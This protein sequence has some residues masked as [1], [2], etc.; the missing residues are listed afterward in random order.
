MNKI[1]IFISIVLITVLFVEAQIE[2]VESP[3]EGKNQYENDI[4]ELNDTVQKYLTMII[5][6]F[7]KLTYYVTYGSVTVA[8]VSVS[9]PFLKVSKLF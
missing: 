6:F 7:N 1:A 3:P 4:N 5:N 9:L 2:S 8:T